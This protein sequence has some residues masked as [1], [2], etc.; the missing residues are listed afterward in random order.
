ML[1]QCLDTLWMK[2]TLSPQHSVPLTTQQATN[3]SQT[4]CDAT[5]IWI[6]P[7]NFD[8]IKHVESITISIYGIPFNLTSSPQYTK[9]FEQ[10]R[11]KWSEWSPIILKF[12]T[13]LSFPR[14]SQFSQ[15]SLSMPSPT[16][17]ATSSQISQLE[18]TS[19]SS[20]TLHI[21]Y[22]LYYCL[23]PSWPFL[24]LCMNEFSLNKKQYTDPKRLASNLTS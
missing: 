2:K 17:H 8:V 12:D 21:L 16:T 19:C 10:L 24:P 20:N 23:Q 22:L 3:S 11:H 15:F 1:K 13:D 18:Q 6:L 5:K 14:T 4:S 7:K 9:W